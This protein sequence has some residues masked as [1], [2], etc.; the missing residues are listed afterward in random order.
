MEQEQSMKRLLLATATLVV[1]FAQCAYAGSIQ[2]I[3]IRQVNLDIFPN[4]GSGENVGFS[5][6]SPNTLIDGIAGTDCFDWCGIADSLPP[7]STLGPSSG[8][9]FDSLQHVT[10]GGKSFDSESSFIFNSSINPAGTVFFPT[11]GNDF[12]VTIPASLD[13]PL[14]LLLSNGKT[15]LVNIPAG[16]LTLTFGFSPAQGDIPATYF[17]SQGSYVATTATPEPGS[18]LLLGTGLVGVLGAARKKLLRSTPSTL[19]GSGGPKTCNPQHD[20]MVGR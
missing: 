16:Q 1:C 19:H 10:I 15:V 9:F 18:F 6:T 20:A 11:D 5:F 3:N 8:L 17:F 2:T 14:T 12:T 4:D 13:S 7:G